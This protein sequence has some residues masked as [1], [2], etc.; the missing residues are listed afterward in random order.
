MD[1]QEI[2][3]IRKKEHIKYPHLFQII[4]IM[5]NPLILLLIYH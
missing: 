5:V 4:H 3:K 2:Q 1:N